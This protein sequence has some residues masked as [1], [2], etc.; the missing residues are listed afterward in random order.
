MSSD[1]G[2]APWATGTASNGGDKCTGS[3]SPTSSGLGDGTAACLTGWSAF[4]N[5]CYRYFTSTANYDTASS[6]CAGYNAAGT[7]VTIPDA[8]THNFVFQLGFGSW[9]SSEFL[10]G[11][12]DYSSSSWDEN[13]LTYTWADGAPY[14]FMMWR[15]GEPN[16][17]DERC[18]KMRNSPDHPN[19][20]FTG[21][22]DDIV[23]TEQ[24]AYICQ[25]PAATTVSPTS[26]APTAANCPVNMLR[27]LGL[28]DANKFS[29][30][31]FSA[32][33]TNSACS[34]F[35][36][37]INWQKTGWCQN[38]NLDGGY[39][40][41]DLGHSSLTGWTA[42]TRVAAI[43]TQSRYDVNEYV[44]QYTVQSSNDGSSF[45]DVTDS[46]SS[47]TFTGNSG[48][49]SIVTNKFS[50]PV[51]AR[52]FRITP[53]AAFAWPSLRMELFEC[54][55]EEVMCQPGWEYLSSNG[56][57]YKINQERQTWATA[58]T[59]CRGDQGGDLA[60]ISSEEV[61]R[62]LRLMSNHDDSYYGWL[63]IG[64]YVDD[65]LMTD[66]DQYKWRW[67]DGAP[68][69]EY[70]N[71]REELHGPN[72]NVI[73]PNDPNEQCGAITWKWDNNRAQQEST[74]IDV[75][76]DSTNYY[77]CQYKATSAPTSTTT[78]TISKAPTTPPT[79][80]RGSCAS[81]FRSITGDYTSGGTL[82]GLGGV[83]TGRRPTR[84]G[85]GCAAMP[86]CA[87]YKCG[88]SPP[89]ALLLFAKFRDD[90]WNHRIYRHRLCSYRCEDLR[91]VL[92]LQNV[93]RLHV[94]ECSTWEWRIGEFC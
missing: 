75:S 44:T 15:E 59:R 90:L 3:Q 16:S 89:R 56:L 40:T 45:S 69:G 37:R 78:P 91:N 20:G 8:A 10:I 77:A 35:Y 6:N 17:K 81:G 72:G 47:T 5:K 21:S 73:E 4:R 11:L 88:S 83:P 31:G 57:C 63:W 25:Y 18:V 55:G 65:A 52:F 82:N 58:Q 34:P 38:S 61:A 1:G 29:S 71:W 27:P 51:Q 94:D 9:S 46:S 60:T 48:Y 22:W 12:R 14:S 41:V 13:Y 32:S 43:A 33:S 92:R 80:L 53:T 50:S 85:W 84:A 86:S 49:G 24:K 26:S 39:L 28:V 54:S 66:G 36:A 67:S 93:C 64:A 42:A 19:V 30:A 68:W 2:S 7:L 79:V 76:C 87:A 70:V 74:W 23:C 62:H